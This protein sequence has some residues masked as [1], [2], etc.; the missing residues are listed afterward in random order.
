MARPVR[1]VL[2]I[3]AAIFLGLPLLAAIGPG[4]VGGAFRMNAPAADELTCSFPVDHVC[5]ANANRLEDEA[6]RRS[7]ATTAAPRSWP[8]PNGNVR[9]LPSVA[10]ARPQ[11]PPPRLPLQAPG[12]GGGIL[13][14]LPV[15]GRALTEGLKALPSGAVP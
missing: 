14:Q 12:G 13:G 6:R 4:L 15:V 2:W 5:P 1:T 11:A 3:A 7:T 10:A 9:E 8:E